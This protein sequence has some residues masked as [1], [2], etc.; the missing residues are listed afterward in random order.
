MKV[1]I[2]AGGLGSRLS[3]E[4]VVRPKPMVEI[5]GKP[6]LWHIMGIYAGHG[7]RDFVVACGYKGEAIKEY[8]RNFY[9]INTDLV[10]SLRDGSAST[11]NPQS[12]D[13]RIT[14]VDTGL[15]T[16]TG[17]RIRRLASVLGNSTFM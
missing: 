14:M 8:F 16:Q 15:E 12:P 10:V 4:T 13:W 11:L 2:L 5:G 3:E 7:Y 6:I 9:F 17:G 1:V